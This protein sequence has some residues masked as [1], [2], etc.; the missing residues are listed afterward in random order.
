MVWEGAHVGADAYQKVFL[1]D[2]ATRRQLLP[3]AEKLN[4]EAEE[5]EPARD[6]LVLLPQNGDKPTLLVGKNNT[7]T[8]S[9]KSPC[10][11]LVTI[12]ATACG[13][14]VSASALYSTIEDKA[15]IMSARAPLPA[16]AAWG[17]GS[18]AVTSLPRE[19][20]T[21]SNN[22][23]KMLANTSGLK[24]S[25]RPDSTEVASSLI[26]VVF[27][28]SLRLDGQKHIWL[29]QMERLSRA[30]FAPKYLKFHEEGEIKEAP[31]QS[32]MR[33]APALGRRMTWRFSREGYRTPTDVPLVRTSSP[34]MKAS[35]MSE[36]IDE[37]ATDYVLMNMGFGVVLESIDSAGDRPHLMSPEWPRDLF[38]VVADAIKRASPDVLVIPKSVTL[39]DVVLTRAASWAMGNRGVM[40]V[41]DFPNLYPAKGQGVDPLATPSHFVARHPD[42]EAL[43]AYLKAR[44]RT[45]PPGIEVASPV[46]SPA[47]EEGASGAP[48]SKQRSGGSMY[49][50][51]CDSDVMTVLGCRDPDC[52]VVGFAGRL[53][54]EKGARL[55]LAVA[56]VLAKL[57]PC[58]V[59]F[60]VGDGPLRAGLEAMAERLG[61]ASQSV[62]TPV[63]A[64]GTG[65]MLEYLSPNVNTL[66]LDEAEPHKVATAVAE[67]LLD[68][69]R[70]DALAERGIRDVLLSNFQVETAV[71]RWA[72]LYEKLLGMLRRF[73]PVSRVVRA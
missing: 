65:G 71:E 69:P 45:N 54:R 47:A 13:R 62:G 10:T 21:D 53:A 36:S 68:G 73:G 34:R 17:L 35:W 61:L 72:E 18:G 64:F 66:V 7:V 26:S 24:V 58:V 40:I 8:I 42:I 30:R 16:D 3:A 46:I 1:G 51:E 28:G 4:A 11:Q 6:D 22:T 44:V 60:L 27:L 59:F 9:V 63:A 43:A 67:L 12:F 70:L 41:M 32:P 14:R 37:R 5:P 57:L 29:H 20:D 19:P 38:L 52:H 25:R 55:F 2:D 31:R 15:T 33:K 56:G 23:S 39:G 49:D 50:L 48:V